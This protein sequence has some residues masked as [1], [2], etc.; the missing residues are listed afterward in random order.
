MPGTCPVCGKSNGRNKNA[1]SHACY[2]KLRMQYKKCPICGDEFHDPHSNATKTC[3]KPECSKVY[4]QQLYAKGVYDAALDKAHEVIRI[5]P[6]TGRFETHVNA[7]TWIIKA[8]DGQIYECRNLMHWLR[9]HEDLLDGT[10]KQAWDGITKIKYTMQGKRPRS[11]SKSWK[12]W[13]LIEY[14]E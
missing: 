12:G 6:L 7:K 2:A 3:R 14:G 1:C 8:P 11:K 5:H 13:T 10:A 4:R 9:E